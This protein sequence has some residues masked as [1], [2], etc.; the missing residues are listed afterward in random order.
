MGSAGAAGPASGS[1]GLDGGGVWELGGGQGCG[2][3]GWDMGGSGV[4]HPVRKP[5]SGAPARATPGAGMA[6]RQK[7]EGEDVYR[8][9]SSV[10]PG[11][12]MPETVHPTRGTPQTSHVP[13]RF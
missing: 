10:Q 11:T 8:V 4:T 1:G 2:E 3:A 7:G 13:Q 6:R 5:M 9:V 12:V